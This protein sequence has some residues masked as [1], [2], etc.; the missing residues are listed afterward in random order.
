[1]ASADDQQ[2]ACG[3]VTPS[4]PDRKDTVGRFDECE[5]VTHRRTWAEFARLKVA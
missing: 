1:M 3:L 4:S 5:Q 2:A